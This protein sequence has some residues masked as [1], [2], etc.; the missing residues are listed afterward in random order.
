MSL[1]EHHSNL[2][3]RLTLSIWAQRTEQFGP[4]ALEREPVR[5][6]RPDQR[7]PRRP[8]RLRTACVSAYPLQRSAF[9]DGSIHRWLIAL[10]VPLREC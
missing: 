10:Y 3:S 6:S 4:V 9:A 5:A 2:V 1:H 8:S 7:G